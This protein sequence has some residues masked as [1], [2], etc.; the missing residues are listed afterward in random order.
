[1]WVKLDTIIKKLSIA[2]CLYPHNRIDVTLESPF[3]QICTLLLRQPHLRVFSYREIVQRPLRSP[4]LAR[5]WNESLGS[6]IEFIPYFY[7]LVR[8]LPLPL[9]N[10]KNETGD[11]SRA[12]V[13]ICKRAIAKLGQ[14]RH[15]L[16]VKLEAEINTSD[17]TYDSNN[18]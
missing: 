11:C 7:F 3:N 16:V 9:Q 5:R 13:N 1:M 12:T 4:T 14:E 15:I 18:Q 2:M 17:S 6:S 10:L 8:L